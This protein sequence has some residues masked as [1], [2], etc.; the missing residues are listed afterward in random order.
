MRILR[1]MRRRRRR[2]KGVL[3]RKIEERNCIITS[4]PGYETSPAFFALDWCGVAVIY[5]GLA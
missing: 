2:E 5:A 1:P 4:A 3:C